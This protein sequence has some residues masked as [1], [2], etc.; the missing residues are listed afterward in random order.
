MTEQIKKE[1]VRIAKIFGI[2]TLN[3]KTEKTFGKTL[4]L[5]N[6]VKVLVDVDGELWP[7]Y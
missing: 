1:L 2:R 3:I 4:Y 5:L 7:Y 6:G